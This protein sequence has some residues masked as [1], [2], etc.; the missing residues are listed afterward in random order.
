MKAFILGI[1]LLFGSVAHAGVAVEVETINHEEL[2]CEYAEV[3]FEAIIYY[4]KDEVPVDALLE[5]MLEIRD[6]VYGDNY[7]YN[8]NH[9]PFLYVIH[10]K[11]KRCYYVKGI[12]L[13]NLNNPYGD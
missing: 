8:D 11:Q 7:I 3:G 5:G 12:N 6:R 9:Q 2:D 4:S 1:A 10:D 13:I